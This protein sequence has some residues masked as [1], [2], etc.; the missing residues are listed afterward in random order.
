MTFLSASSP[1]EKVQHITDIE[2][3]SRTLGCVLDAQGVLLGITDRLFA[4]HMGPGVQC[5][6]CLGG[7]ERRGRSDPH[8]MRGSRKHF[9][10]RVKPGQLS[11]LTENRLHSFGTRF[12]D[13]NM[14]VL[15][16]QQKPGVAPADRAQARRRLLSSASLC[17]GEPP[18]EQRVIPAPESN[19]IRVFALRVS[20]PRA[21]PE[22]FEAARPNCLW[23]HFCTLGTSRS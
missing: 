20:D 23:Q 4:E 21:F 18:A 2:Y 7:M 15:A 13:R 10:E 8:D 14:Y 11:Q 6:D 17:S 22:T 19:S 12:D 1:G 9:F 5:S 3:P 16:L